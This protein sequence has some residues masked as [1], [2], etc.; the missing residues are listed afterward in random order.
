MRAKEEKLDANG[1]FLPNTFPPHLT[2]DFLIYNYNAEEYYN[3]FIGHFVFVI[4][5]FALGLGFRV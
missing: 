4:H 5:R 1:V 2:N 3:Q